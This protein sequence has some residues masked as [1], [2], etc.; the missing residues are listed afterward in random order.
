MER[1]HDHLCCILLLF[2]EILFFLLLLL[3]NTIIHITQLLEYYSYYINNW[4]VKI[5]NTHLQLP[6]NLLLLRDAKHFG[7][8]LTY[9]FKSKLHML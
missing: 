8:L 5:L 6:I 2:E 4:L 1:L 7:V 9:N 3:T